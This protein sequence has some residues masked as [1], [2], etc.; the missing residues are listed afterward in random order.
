MIEY[1]VKKITRFA[2]TKWEESPN[3]C[4]HE[5][6]G[7]FDNEDYANRV[8]NAFGALNPNAKLTFLDSPEDEIPPSID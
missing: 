3:H 4:S 5:T 1:R 7:I 8:M 6:V 2:V